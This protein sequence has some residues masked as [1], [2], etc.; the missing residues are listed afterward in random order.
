MKKLAIIHFNPIELYPPAMNWLNYL[1]A[2]PE[3]GM[4]IRVYTMDTPP[5]HDTFHSPA[6]FIKIIRSGNSRR[7]RSSSR[8]MNYLAFYMKAIRLIAWRPGQVLYYETL[9]AIPAILYKKLIN[10]NSRLFIHYHEYTSPKEYRE[11]MILNRWGHKLEKKIYPFVAWLSHTNDDRMGFFKEDNKGITLANTHILP[12]YPPLNWQRKEEKDGSGRQKGTKNDPGSPLRIV[13]VGALSIETIYTKEFAEWVSHQQGRVIW[14]IYSGNMTGEAGAFLSSL[15]SPYIRFRGRIDYY[16]LP[17]VLPDY[18]IGVI[19]YKGS[20]LNHIYSVPN[21][22]FEY[23]AC[24]LDIWF[25]EALKSCN[26]F[27]AKD[28]CPKI[29]PV[30]FERLD[31]LDL[32]AVADHSGLTHKPSSYYCEDVLERLFE[33]MQYV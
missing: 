24:G 15:N 28:R 25:S 6:S 3:G 17:E 10:R 13:H 27:M 16:S 21:K 1:A 7:Q 33:T 5:D 26:P 30:D 14:D 23:W 8:Y 20:T 12:N 9:S 4:E 11:G 29:I 19:L 2:H 32:S 22:L 18:D 31:A